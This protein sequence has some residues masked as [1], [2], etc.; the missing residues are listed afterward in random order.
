M[1][2][3]GEI[4]RPRRGLYGT[5]KYVGALRNRISTSR[6]RAKK[7][8][9]KLKTSSAVASRAADPASEYTLKMHAQQQAMDWAAK[10]KLAM[11]RAAELRDQRKL[12]VVDDNHTF[13][14]EK[15]SR[16][17][18]DQLGHPNVVGRDGLDN[19]FGKHPGVPLYSEQPFGSDPVPPPAPGAGHRQMMAADQLTVPGPPL[20]GHAGNAAHEGM[21]RVSM[22]SL[23]SEVVRHGGPALPDGPVGSGSAARPDGCTGSSGC[24]CAKCYADSQFQSMLRGGSRPAAAGALNDRPAWQGSDENEA[25]HRH[26]PAYYDAMRSELSQP[27]RSVACWARAAFSIAVCVSL[28]CT[29]RR[30]AQRIACHHK[31]SSPCATF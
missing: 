12:G 26:G 25:P 18:P 22:D 28:S 19:Y 13:Q 31:P 24:S 23:S 10:R 20:S 16:A 21:A 3:V 6:G 2:G 17:R 15:I 5:P 11:E 8:K 30:A 14:P 29:R 4:A 1:W 27:D 9:R 7:K